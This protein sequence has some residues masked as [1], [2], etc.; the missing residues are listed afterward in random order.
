MVKMKNV[1]GLDRY[2]DATSEKLKLDIKMIL[3][4][5]TSLKRI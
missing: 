3:Y 2:D 4:Y 1:R 5:V